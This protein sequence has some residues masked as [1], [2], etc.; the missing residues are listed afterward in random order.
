MSGETKQGPQSPESIENKDVPSAKLSITATIAIEEIEKELINEFQNNPKSPKL[1]ELITTFEEI[2][3]A[4]TQKLSEMLGK[5]TKDHKFQDY[6][7]IKIPITDTLIPITLKNGTTV[8]IPIEWGF[9]G[10]R[11]DFGYTT[12][13]FQ[14]AGY[15]VPFVQLQKALMWAKLMYLWDD[16]TDF[17]GPSVWI[18]TKEPRQ[19]TLKWHGLNICSTWP[20]NNMDIDWTDPR[21]LTMR[22]DDFITLK[23]TEKPTEKPC[24]CFG[25]L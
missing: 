25:G 4:F 6:V 10:T 12:T 8:I 21:V 9:Y 2:I 23:L 3:D 11:T 15:D 16:S 20:G 18:G 17:D 19:E 14:F 13:S 5:T 1:I 7:R 24:S 22:R